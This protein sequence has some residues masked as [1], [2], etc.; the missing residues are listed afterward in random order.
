MQERF[1]TYLLVLK[2]QQTDTGVL[3]AN[4]ALNKYIT[5]GNHRKQVSEIQRFPGQDNLYVVTCSKSFMEAM[6]KSQKMKEYIEEIQNTEDLAAQTTNVRSARKS[7][8]SRRAA[9]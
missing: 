1:Q 5:S 6:A 4:V 9:P 7:T 2:D 8:I 3:L